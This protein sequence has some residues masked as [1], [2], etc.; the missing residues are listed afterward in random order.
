MRLVVAR[1]SELGG[2]R[3]GGSGLVDG[4]TFRDV[5]A[6]SLICVTLPLRALVAAVPKK[7]RGEKERCE[8]LVVCIVQMKMGSEAGCGENRG[9]GAHSSPCVCWRE[10]RRDRRRRRGEGRKRE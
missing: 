6:A 4:G 7:N 10:E 3:G 9:I 8:W 1:L 5:P 2:E